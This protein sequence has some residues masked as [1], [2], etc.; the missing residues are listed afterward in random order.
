MKLFSSYFFNFS[1]KRGNEKN[2]VVGCPNN[3]KVYEYK[4]VYWIRF[5][6]DLLVE[7]S[8]KIEKAD[9]FLSLKTFLF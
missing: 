6:K 3:L 4:E 7:K 1:S 9:T 2:I 8:Q 5:E